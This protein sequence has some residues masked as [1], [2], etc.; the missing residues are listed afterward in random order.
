[1]Q[2][3]IPLK[4]VICTSV[5]TFQHIEANQCL[6]I[7]KYLLGHSFSKFCFSNSK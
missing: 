1:M 2:K 5:S 7:V 3:R 4:R 6:L